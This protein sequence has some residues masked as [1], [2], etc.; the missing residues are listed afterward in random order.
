MTVSSVDEFRCV[1]QEQSMAVGMISTKLDCRLSGTSHH[2]A[3]V[4]RLAYERR[5]DGDTDY[6]I[7]E[8]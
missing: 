4:A 5:I 7:T 3:G 1:G 8:Q 2:L 6:E